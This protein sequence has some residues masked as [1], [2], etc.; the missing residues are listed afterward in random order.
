M[1]F[2]IIT[3][4]PD[5]FNNFLNESLLARAQKKKLLKINLYNLRKW[6]KDRHKTVDDRPYGGGAGMLLKI[7]P[8]F[9]AVESLKVKKFKSSKLKTRTILLSA[10]GKTFT[11]KDARRLSKYDRLIFVCGRY[12][13]VDERVAKYVADE[14]ISIG[15]YVLF[16]GEVAA[17]VII[18]AVSRLVP[19]V[20]AKPESVKYESFSDKGSKAKEYPQYTRPEVITLNGKKLRV[21]KVLLSGNHGEI[22]KWRKRHSK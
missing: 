17:M 21:P 12:E 6:T 22:E 16:G 20:I 4:F 19:G 5:L 1:K 2:D 15:N 8:I 14:E 18:E 13:G 9:R 3:I 11:Q 7:E 10:K